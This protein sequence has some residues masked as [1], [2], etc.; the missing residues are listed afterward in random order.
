[1]KPANNYDPLESVISSYSLET[2]DNAIYAD[3]LLETT[4]RELRA[5]VNNYL[6]TLKNDKRTFKLINKHASVYYQIY[7]EK[8]AEGEYLFGELHSYEIPVRFPF[9]DILK[10]KEI[11]DEKAYAILAFKIM[12]LYILINED[13][14][15]GW[16]DSTAKMKFSLIIDR[17]F[18]FYFIGE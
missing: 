2:I 3:E 14:R 7:K 8:H 4:K 18:F 1:M 12:Q 11:P 13:P 5:I 15:K 9:K 10:T 17:Y 16:H 6:K